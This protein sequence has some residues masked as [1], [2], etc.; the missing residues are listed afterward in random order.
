MKWPIRDLLNPVMTRSLLYGTN[1]FDM[2]YVLKKMDAIQVMSGK[3][4]KTVW[5]GEW[6][7]KAEK[8][9]NLA[10]NAVAQDNRISACAYFKLETQCHY[11]SYMINMDDVEK[12]QEIYEKLMETYRTYLGYKKNH[13]EYVEIPTP[14]GDMPAYLHYPDD[15]KQGNYPCVITYSG[16]GSCKEELEMLA[17]PLLERGMA[18]LTTDMPGTGSA[19]FHHGLKCNGQ[20]LEPAFDA[21]FAFLTK[22]PEIDAARI[23]NMGLCMGGGYAFRATAKH[24]E[25][26]CCVSLFPLFLN[27]ADMGSIPIWMKRGKWAN[28]QYGSE[29]RQDDAAFLEGMKKLES[30]TVAADFLMVYSEDDNWMTTEAS[31]SLFER[32]TG[33][34]EK[35]FVDEKPAYVS[36]ESIMHAMPVGEQF[37]WVQHQAAD[38]LAAR[39]TKK[40]HGNGTDVF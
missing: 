26:A 6:N 38:F 11:A 31:L 35:I 39:L 8:Y 19:L 15:G 7:R 23:G 34:K 25:V 9:H 30:G 33:T 12:K 5:L 28:F 2:E 18:V 37:H 40:E 13:T 1:P 24:P 3:E 32:A 16:I 20:M 29:M 14:Y 21:A 4:I 10:T 17:T 27:L 36:E 22:R